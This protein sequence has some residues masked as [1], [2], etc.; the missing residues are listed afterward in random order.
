M[1]SSA[2]HCITAFVPAGCCCIDPARQMH[3]RLP[4][5]FFPSGHGQQQHKR[6]VQHHISAAATGKKGRGAAAAAASAG[7][8]PSSSSSS[9][10]GLQL[11]KFGLKRNEDE[12]EEEGGIEED[13]SSGDESSPF[14]SVL[15]AWKRLNEGSRGEGLVPVANVLGAARSASVRRQDPRTVFVAGANGQIGARSAQKLLRQGLVVRGGVRDLFAAQQLA[16]FATQYGV[17]PI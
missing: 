17:R 13:G 15:E 7:D 5:F 11:F 16:E 10:R 3:A 2:S 8:E 9:S 14:A 1:A 6:H 4:G 12:E